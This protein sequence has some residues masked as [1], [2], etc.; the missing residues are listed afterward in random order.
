MF[1]IYSNKL[2]CKL[3]Q[4]CGDARQL[5]EQKPY[6]GGTTNHTKCYKVSI[7]IKGT[8]LTVQK[9]YR[10]KES[11]S[12]NTLLIYLGL[13]STYHLVPIESSPGKVYSFR[14]YAYMATYVHI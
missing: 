4:C 14:L 9:Q 10:L 2:F 7:Y 6:K 1:S 11:M 13:L 8:S 12:M 5:Y 3:F